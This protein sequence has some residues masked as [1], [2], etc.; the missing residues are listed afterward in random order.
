MHSVFSCRR[1][2]FFV[3]LA[4]AALLGSPVAWGESLVGLL[5]R[6]RAG[7][8]A[9]LSAAADVDIASAR[10]SL[11]RAALLPQLSLSATTNEHDRVYQTRLA[12]FP[13]AK[14]RYRGVS[15][16]LNLTQALIRVPEI[17]AL[18]Q[19]DHVLAQARHQYDSA[20]QALKTRLL[21]VWFD[22]L[23]ARDNEVFGVRQLQ[24][25]ERQWSIVQRGS[26]LGLYSEVHL[27]DAR[28][29]LEQGRADLATARAELAVQHAL[30]ELLTGPLTLER[31][32]VLDADAD[33]DDLLTEGLDHWLEASVGGNP[34]LRA[35]LSAFSAATAEV[36]KQRAGH[37]PTLELVASYGNTG[38]GAGGFPG[39]AGYDIRQTSVGVQLALP[40]YSGGAQSARVQEAIAQRERARH[41]IELA[42]RQ[43]LVEVRQAWLGW[44]SARARALAGRQTLTS[45]RAALVHAQRGLARGVTS[46]FEVLQA[47]QQ[48]L[49]AQRD[50]HK[51]R[52]DQLIATVRMRAG[53]G[54]LRDQDFAALD[55]LMTTP[56]A[57]LG[58]LARADR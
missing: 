17:M 40:L 58:E 42:R 18:R 43:A 6:A 28:A 22:L 45:A 48:V 47:E 44:G 12:G 39:Q 54:L 8:P 51:A 55:A 4:A 2:V 31:L 24:T 57:S 33:L 56:R 20:E 10:K 16:Q 25:L 38:Q 41:E 1:G 13:D 53:A 3:V 35:S 27:K 21:T 37:L 15:Q 50:F 26:A 14:D 32:P 29:R 52:Y 30:L 19:S 9:F 36:G 34:A 7:E 11:A 49:A 5:E 23:A 46:D